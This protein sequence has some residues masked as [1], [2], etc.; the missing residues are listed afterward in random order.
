MEWQGI[1]LSG[2]RQQQ[3]VK[4]SLRRLSLLGFTIVIAIITAI[5]LWHITQSYQQQLSQYQQQTG[6]LQTQLRQL[7]Q[8]YQQLR[9]RQ[10]NKQPAVYL[11]KQTL[12]QFI[13]Y[14]NQLSVQGVI[15][16][17]QLYIENGAKLKLIGQ[18]MHQTQLERLTQQ[19]KQLGYPYRFDQ[20]QTH[21]QDQLSFS[22]IIQFT[23]SHD[24]TVD[25][26]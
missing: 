1:N 4:G 7:E 11:T 24:E 9:S 26:P 12:Q 6:Q 23:R 22:L 18:L 25:K 15:D 5:I 14:L 20:V 10:A 16:I 2:Y 17:S 8:Q 13:D 3:W 21:E 19:L